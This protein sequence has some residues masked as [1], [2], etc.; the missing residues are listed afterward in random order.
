MVLAVWRWCGKFCRENSS[1]WGGVCI[2]GEI[3]GMEGR[4]SALSGEGVDWS[5]V[6]MLGMR[7]VGSVERVFLSWG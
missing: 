3:I 4:I 6:S 2:M 1:D 5:S 7:C